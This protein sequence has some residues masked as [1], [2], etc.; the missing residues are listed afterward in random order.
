[1]SLRTA[2]Y[3]ARTEL[4]KL[5]LLWIEP[6]AQTDRNTQIGLFSLLEFGIFRHGLFCARPH[7]VDA[8]DDIRAG[9]GEDIIVALEV[10]RVV[11]ELLPCASPKVSG[12]V[13]GAAVHCGRLNARWACQAKHPLRQTSPSEREYMM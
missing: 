4:V 12:V 7:L 8:V 9:D 5:R 10:L 11:P 6:S 13:L 2:G 3:T 1:M